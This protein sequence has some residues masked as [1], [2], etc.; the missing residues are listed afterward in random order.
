MVIDKSVE[1]IVRARNFPEIQ[2]VYK[3]SVVGDVIKITQ[4]Q[5]LTMARC[6]KLDCVCDVCNKEYTQTANRIND[7]PLR[8]QLCGDCMRKY[9]AEN[10]VSTMRTEKK[11]KEQSEKLFRFCSTEEGK[12]TRK[13][14]GKRHSV[15]LKSRPDLIEKFTTYLVHKTGEDHPNFNPNKTEFLQYWREVKTVT[16]RTYREYLDIINPNRHERTLCGVE[17]GYQ[18]DHIISVKQGFDEGISPEII[19]GL[20]NLQ[21]LPWEENRKKWHK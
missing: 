2:K 13:S 8:E 16:E 11:R 6:R 10:M 3:T 5:C 17:N 21:M 7:I 14:F 9:G 4:Q 15:Y 12:Q 20:D 19:G 1:I 18:L